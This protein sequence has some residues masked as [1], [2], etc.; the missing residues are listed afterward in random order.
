MIILTITFCLLVKGYWTAYTFQ[1]NYHYIS[2]FDYHNLHISYLTAANSQFLLSSLGNIIQTRQLH[3]VVRWN[4]D[5]A[6]THTPL[7]IC[8]MN[9]TKPSLTTSSN[10]FTSDVR[11]HFFY[12]KRMVGWK[13]MKFGTGIMPYVTTADS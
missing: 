11:L 8:I 9:L 13:L 5:D 12:N 6:T 10:I 3:E 2:S 1:T 7:C 4:D